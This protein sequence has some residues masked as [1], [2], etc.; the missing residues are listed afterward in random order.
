MKT[1]RRDW[2]C[3]NTSEY[4]RIPNA[5]LNLTAKTCVN[6][7][8]GKRR[9][10]Q[11]CYINRAET[12]FAETPKKS[13]HITNNII[14]MHWNFGDLSLGFQ[15]EYEEQKAASKVWGIA[16][17]LVCRSAPGPKPKFKRWPEVEIH[18]AALP[19]APQRTRLRETV[20]NSCGKSPQN[21]PQIGSL[22]HV[23]IMPERLK[24]FKQKH[25]LIRPLCLLHSRERS[26]GTCGKLVSM[27]F[28]EARLAT[29]RIEKPQPQAHTCKNKNKSEG[30]GMLWKA[31]ACME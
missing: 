16:F 29:N 15:F 21:I 17:N 24:I 23:Q 19:S 30:I 9:L 18:K 20:E 28:A 5:C 31:L 14:G 25:F 6:T 1:R 26:P 7:C 27:V 22:K 3:W 2:I 10:H 4:V 11:L 13:K 12:N 8:T